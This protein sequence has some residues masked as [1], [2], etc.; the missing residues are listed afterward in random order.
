[1]KISMPCLRIS[2]ALLCLALWG[3][4]SAP[5]VRAQTRQAAA[6]HEAAAVEADLRRR[7]ANSLYR[8]KRAL[9]RD[10]YPSAQAA[11][12]IWRAD[13]MAAGSFDETQ[14]RTYRREIYRKSVENITKWF[15]VCLQEKWLREADYCR[16][17]YRLHA[18]AIHIF[19]EAQ[20]EEMNEKLAR[21][22]KEVEAEEKRH[23]SATR[24]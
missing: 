10:R 14:Y 15:D 9:R 20:Y 13:A 19:D 5:G 23:R 4:G 21:L 7:A 8:L 6:G 1:M 16:K 3:A 18:R 17:I 24:N 22:K 11:L 12:N 2:A